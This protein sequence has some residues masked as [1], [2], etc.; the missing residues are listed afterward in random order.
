MF[1][2]WFWYPVPETLA[3]ANIACKILLND[4][5]RTSYEFYSAYQNHRRQHCPKFENLSP[6]ICKWNQSQMFH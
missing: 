1:H 6:D 5:C 4:D 3:S 2:S